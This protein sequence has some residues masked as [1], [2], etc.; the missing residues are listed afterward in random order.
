MAELRCGEELL[1]QQ[2]VD[3]ALAHTRD[4][5]RSAALVVLAHLP[6][7]S[8][9]RAKGSANAL[10][11]KVNLTPFSHDDYILYDLKG[12]HGQVWAYIA[13]KEGLESGKEILRARNYL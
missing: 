5:E 12:K 6:K 11:V 7:P 3:V 1:Q 10:P 8:N 4:V 9:E 2:Q 13:A